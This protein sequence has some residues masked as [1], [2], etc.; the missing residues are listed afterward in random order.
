MAISYECICR[1]FL[2]LIHDVADSRTQISSR[3]QFF[4]VEVIRSI[5]EYVVYGEKLGRSFMDT[6]IEKNTLQAFS[7]VLRL[8]NRAVNLQL[9]QTTSILLAN[10]KDT[11]ARCKSNNIS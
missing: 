7:M 5:A 10:I 6:L 1:E 9:I 3:N 8:N 2:K 11:Q 4:M